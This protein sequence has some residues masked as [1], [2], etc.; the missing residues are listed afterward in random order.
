MTEPHESA[1]DPE[2]VDLLEAVVLGDATDVQIARLNKIL[3]SDGEKRRIAARFLQDET[4]L[5]SEFQLF[6]RIGDFSRAAADDIAEPATKDASPRGWRFGSSWAW[7]LAA[8]V[9]VAAYILSYRGVRPPNGQG[10]D[11]SGSEAAADSG[12]VGSFAE[13]LGREQIAD[14]ALSPGAGLRIGDVVEISSGVSRLKFDRGADVCLKGPAKL[15]IITPMRAALEHGA[16]TARVA[17]NAHGFRIDTPNSKV[18]DLG[19]EFGVSVSEQGATEM[20]VF[21]GKVAMEYSAPRE[22]PNSEP[23]SE[24]AP[25]AAPTLETEAPAPLDQA[26]LFSEGEALRVTSDGAVERVMAVHNSDFPRIGA[27]TGE[28]PS[29]LPVIE[30]VS[31]SLRVDDTNM[32]YQISHHGFREDA[33]AYVDRPYEWNGLFP[34][35]GLPHCLRNADYIMPFCDDKLNAQIEMRVTLNRPARLYVLFDNRAELPAWLTEQFQD[36]GYYVGIDESER[37][38]AGFSLATGAG[39]SLDSC[40]SVW[41][42]DVPK[43]GVVVLGAMKP[44]NTSLMYGVAAVPLDIAERIAAEPHEHHTPRIGDG[45]LRPPLLPKPLGTALVER[46]RSFRNLTVATPSDNDVASMSRGVRFRIENMDG[47]LMPHPSVQV[48]GDVLPALNDG[49]IHRNSD[50]KERCVWYN[51]QGRFSVDLLSP[52][53]ITAINVFSCHRVERAPQF[54]TV[55]GSAADVKPSANFLRPAEAIAAGWQFIALVN[56]HPLG[57]GGVHASSVTAAPNTLGPFRHL[58]FIAERQVRGTFFD[59]IDVHTASE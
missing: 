22:E 25:E 59:E 50:D 10:V 2:L 1:V 56:T 13:G 16:L 18:I 48:Q 5:R 53:Q 36:T 55:W 8:S 54:Y 9:I 57:D 42:C 3:L 19:T 51:G 33:R 44:L 23:E 7:A 32:C 11:R 52:E 43:A 38:A 6:H 58:L 37:A 40:M 45:N 49:L 31:D 21:S 30:A 26:K 4:V 17:E 39:Q 46:V 41:S 27:D 20:V 15:T 29:W 12:L 34:E 47:T 24:P 14:K 35:Y 28:E